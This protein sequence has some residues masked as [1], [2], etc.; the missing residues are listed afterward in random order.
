MGVSRVASNGITSG[1]S[2]F[3]ITAD[4]SGPMS[5]QRSSKVR[6]TVGFS[7]TGSGSRKW[8]NFMHRIC[9]RVTFKRFESSI[10]RANLTFTLF[11]P[12]PRFLRF[13]NYE[14][15]LAFLAETFQHFEEYM[16]RRHEIHQVLPKRR[17]YL[18]HARKYIL[19]GKAQMLSC[20]LC[21][22]IMRMTINSSRFSCFL[23]LPSEKLIQ[24]HYW[25]INLSM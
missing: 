10:H 20:V 18:N 24:S 21:Y 2:V 11:S 9:F 4:N 23:L 3:C 7:W 25:R 14:M 19:T 5:S 22:I 12:S 16:N 13:L 8:N 15:P 6:G 17:M 1:I